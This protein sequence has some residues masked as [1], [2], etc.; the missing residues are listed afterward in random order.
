MA[1]IKT[2]TNKEGR[3]HVYLVEG[4]RKDG[5]VRQRILKKYG[6]MV[7]DNLI[8]DKVLE[9]AISEGFFYVKEYN[10]GKKIV[11]RC[12][13]CFTKKISIITVVK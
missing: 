11:I 2:T 13:L 4:Y 6:W 10:R 8:E 1:F 12:L 5:K 7:L 9:T 3:T